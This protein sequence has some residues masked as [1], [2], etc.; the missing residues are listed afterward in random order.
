MEFID[1]K[2]I[3]LQIAEYL[4]DKILLN[5][6][7]ED[8]KIISIRE[9]A[10][11]VEVNPNTVMRAYEYLQQQEIIFTRRGMG[12]FVKNGA[13]KKIL[14]LKK[15]IFIKDDLPY[16]FKNFYL[17]NLNFKELEDQYKIFINHYTETHENK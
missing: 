14:K 12:Y 6:F 15:Q 5:E 13:K 2:A 9:M 7:T 1:K 8:H 3:Y 16:F 11:H 10:V 17:L 4:C